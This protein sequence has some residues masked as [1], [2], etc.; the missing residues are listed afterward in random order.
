MN[1]ISRKERDWSEI[2]AKTLELYKQNV[3]IKKISALLQV[4]KDYPTSVAR[5]YG[6][7]RGSGRKSDVPDSI[8]DLGTP[9]SE[10][11]L[12][13]IISDGNITCKERQHNIMIA[14]VDDDIIRK[15][16]DYVPNANLHVRK[17]NLKTV[18]FG[19][20]SIVNRLIEMGITPKKSLTIKLNFEL[21]GHVLRGIFDGNGN[22]KKNANCCKIT[23]GSYFLSTQIS[24]FLSRQGIYSAVRKRKDSNCYDVHVERK[25]DFIK[26]YNLLYSES[27]PDTRMDRKY[28]KY[29]EKINYLLN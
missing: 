13:Y 1:P 23:M 20:K 27:T 4:S 5:K 9:V 15:F 29:T 7:M 14:S 26:L 24:E 11:W 17:S 3:E 8:F 25:L 21:T 2:E 19:S 12:G 10:Y 18:Y 16:M 28:L 22:I 6:I